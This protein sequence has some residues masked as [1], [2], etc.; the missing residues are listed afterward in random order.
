MCHTVALVRTYEAELNSTSDMRVSSLRDFVVRYADFIYTKKALEALNRAG[1]PVD[2]D[3]WLRHYRGTCN[4]SF[5]TKGN[6]TGM[7][8]KM[9]KALQK[10]AGQGQAK[11]A[12]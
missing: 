3:N 5:I 9:K 8:K 10:C 2:I 1:T 11:R 7:C 12:A 4:L 6:I